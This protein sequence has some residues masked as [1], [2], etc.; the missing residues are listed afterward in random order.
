[1]I[2]ITVVMIACTIVLL[3]IQWGVARRRRARARARREQE[4]NE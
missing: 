4:R 3:N 2:S 1:M